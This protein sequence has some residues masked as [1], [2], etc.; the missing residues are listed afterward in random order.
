M[1]NQWAIGFEFS[2]LKQ[3]WRRVDHELPIAAEDTIFARDAK[4]GH[5]TGVRE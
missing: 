3:L 4:K 5:R 2:F 1:G